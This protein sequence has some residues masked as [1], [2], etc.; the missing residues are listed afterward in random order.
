V[1]TALREVVGADE[2]LAALPERCAL[3]VDTYELLAPIDTWLRDQLLPSLPGGAMVVLAGRNPLPAGWRVDPAWQEMARSVRL[4]NLSD[5]DAVDY[6]ERRQVPERQREAVLRFTRGFPLA[7]SLAAEVLLQRPG[8]SFEGEAPQ[9]VVRT[10]LERFVAG[11]PSL[12]HR[13]AL[14]ACSQVR[15][16]TE[17]LLAAMLDAPDARE[18]FEWLR[19]LSFVFSGARGLFPHD[20][21]REALAAD[22]KW[23]NPRWKLELH[24]RARRHYMAEFER[25]QGHAQH[26]A[27]LDL[28]YLHDSPLIRSIFTWNE[29]GGLVEDTPRAADL[30]ALL[31]MV[32]AHEGQES[33]QLAQAYF[34]HQPESVAVF[35]DD[36]GEVTGF[37]CFV[38]VRPG[39]VPLQDD[40]CMLAVQRYLRTLP[41]LEE[42]QL[43]AVQ[44]F[45]MAR[46]SYQGV[47][48]TQ[49]MIFVASTR[50]VLTTPGLAHSFHVHGFPDAWAPM[51]SQVLIEREP[52][53]DFTLAGRSFGVFTHDWRA[54]PPQYWL[55]LLAEREVE[56]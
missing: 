16:M 24:S 32:R 55:E 36:S 5:A 17:P 56:A 47:S 25:S 53:A 40:P 13:A 22:L 49:G 52:A 18:V 27:L 8:A 54:C 23:R 14:E 39:E 48:P 35:R 26:Q 38:T 42:G 21:A 12:A 46:E 20:L 44:R 33:A 1:R 19:D 9:D 2:P 28:I 51:L 29:I 10:L 6:L 41:E 34:A 7:L 45:W 31:E 43:V 3:L 30:P 15:T 50:Y 37:T 11:V 4:D